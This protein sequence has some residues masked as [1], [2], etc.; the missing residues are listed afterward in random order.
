MTDSFQ[1]KGVLAAA[2]T[3][4][5]TGLAMWPPSLPL[6]GDRNEGARK[7]SMIGIGRGL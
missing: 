6:R 1:G 3:Q 7:T 5:K 4:A 2:A